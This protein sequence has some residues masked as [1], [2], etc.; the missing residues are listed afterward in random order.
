MMRTIFFLLGAFLLGWPVLST[1]QL[2]DT[3][4]FWKL[5]HSTWIASD[6]VPGAVVQSTRSFREKLLNDP[7]RPG[8]HFT[9]PEGDGLPGDPNGAF[10]ANGRYHLMYL[11]RRE[12]RGFSW[13][14]VSSKDMLHWRHHPDAIVPSGNEDGAFS[15]GAFVDDDGTAILSYWQFIALNAGETF[16]DR[17]RATGPSGIA[18]AMSKDNHYDNWQKPDFNPVVE[19]TDWGITEFTDAE[20]NLK[21]VGSADPSNIWKANG[22]Y[23]MLMGN[24]LVLNKYG[25]DAGAPSNYQGDHLY[26]FRSADLKDWEYRGEFYDRNHAWTDISEDNMCPSFLPLPSSAEGGEPSGK[27]LLLFISHNKGAQYYTGTLND[28]NFEPDHHGRMTWVDNAYFAPEALMDGQGRQIMW[29]WIFDDRPDSVKA[30]Y[31]WN[32]TYGLPRTLWLGQDGTLSQ[33]PVAELAQLRQHMQQ[34]KDLV[35]NDGAEVPLP[36]FGH[37]LMEL[38][39]QVD[40]AG[41]TRFGVKVNCSDD[42]REETVIFY[43]DQEKSLQVDTR[44]SSLGYGRKVIERA[45]YDLKDGLLTMRIF[46]DRSIVEVFA[47]DKQ[48]IGRTIYPTLSGTAIK[49]FA[50]GG[51][52]KVRSVKAWELMPANPY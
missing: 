23:Y 3:I 8:Y 10:Y 6:P 1:A 5:H 30:A 17:V 39:I 25:R 29:S 44:L 7:Y 31:G 24:L 27:H 19:S 21:V 2:P 18:L 40:L 4:P 35:V 45:P 43:D 13:G 42:G 47:N 16:A 32:G 38:E 37:E 34:S 28:E 50:S 49:L 26:L 20:G 9:L 33:A 12:G 51:Q 22:Y 48:A 11:Y 52:A 15:G 46:V 14:H 41:A 36:G